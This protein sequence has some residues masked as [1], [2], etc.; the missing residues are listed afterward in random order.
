[1][2]RTLAAATVLFSTMLVVMS[3]S[4]FAAQAGRSNTTAIREDRARL[5]ADRQKLKVDKQ[6]G[7]SAAV[8]QDKAQIKADMEKL[9]ADGGGKQQRRAKKR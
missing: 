5:K 7:N 8:R 2:L 9:K 4:A 3:G 1:M 6:A